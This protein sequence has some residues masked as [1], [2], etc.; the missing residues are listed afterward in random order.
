QGCLGGGGDRTWPAAGVLTGD[1]VMLRVDDRPVGRR[2]ASCQRCWH[3]ATRRA[4]VGRNR[5]AAHGERAQDLTGSSSAL[6]LIVRHHPDCSL[7]PVVILPAA[8]S[9]RTDSLARSAPPPRVSAR[10]S[11]P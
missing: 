2:G 6:I 3:R 10:W 8:K 4:H 7:A 1:A 5:R 11:C 9:N